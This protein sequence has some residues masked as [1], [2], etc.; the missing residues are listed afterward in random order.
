MN[1]SDL[2]K[3]F[4]AKAVSLGFGAVGISEA[5]RLNEEAVRLQSWLE[6][7]FHGSMNYM[8]NYREVR[9]D[10]RL[11]LDGAKSVISFAYNYYNP[12]F[13]T[14]KCGLKISRYASG[15]DYHKVLKAKLK[16]LVRA[17]ETQ[18]G[19]FR[20][21]AFVDSAPIM[22][23]AWAVRSGIGWIGKNGNLIISGKGSFFFLAELIVDIELEYDSPATD[24]CG[25]CR[26]CI[27]ACPT[28]AIVQ[29]FVVDGRRCISYQTIEHKG[30]LDVEL[31]SGNR[32]WIFGCD[33]CQS[34]CPFNRFSV[35]HSEP[36]FIPKETIGKLGKAD[37]S[38]LTKEQYNQIFFGSAVKRAGY[39]ELKRN[40]KHI[41]DQ[42][43]RR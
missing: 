35:L 43:D 31:A 15:R 6:N 37:W 2:T 17:V 42:S 39:E 21:R 10:P 1:R 19:Q 16:R 34:V 32:E 30:E 38:E 40:I 27:D 28:E 7:D 36:D 24:H 26:L 41:T 33:V 23:R 14:S 25:S 3:L 4:K 20:Y 8:E 29:P 9:D 5:V 11:L 13:P 12:E 18:I 22:E